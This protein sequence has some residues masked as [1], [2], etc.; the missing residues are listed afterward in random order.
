M[1]YDSLWEYVKE[2]EA[3]YEW[4][5]YQPEE[6]KVAIVEID[7]LL[8][9]RLYLGREVKKEGKTYWKI[10]WGELEENY[11]S[12]DE[13]KARSTFWTIATWDNR[14]MLV[15]RGSLYKSIDDA[16]KDI[17]EDYSEQETKIIQI[18]SWH[19][20]SIVLYYK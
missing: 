6:I 10:N 11:I 1:Y 5:E 18:N 7:I 16:I 20:L 3:N 8:D 2:G 14:G 13:I 12:Y 17:E 9:P 4:T 15:S 19:T